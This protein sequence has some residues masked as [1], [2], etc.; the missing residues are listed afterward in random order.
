[1]AQVQGSPQGR[2][3]SCSDKIPS[4]A[5][6]KRCYCQRLFPGLERRYEAE[7]GIY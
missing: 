7:A 2:E 6:R 3:Q 1:M 4:K 5:G